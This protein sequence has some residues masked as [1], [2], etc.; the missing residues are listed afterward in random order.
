MKYTIVTLYPD[1]IRPYLDAAILGRAQKNNKIEVELIDLRD[2]GLGKYKQ[3][4][5]TPYGGG[6]GMILRPD[7]VVPAIK[8][9]EQGNKKAR[10]ILLSPEGGQFTQQHAEDIKNDDLILIAGRFEGFDARIKK[11]IDEVVSIG[12]YILCGG[13]IAALAIIEASARLI[14]GVLGNTESTKEE[15]FSNG[16]L[17]YPQYTKPDTYEGTTIPEVLKSGNHAEISKWRQ[18]N[19]RKI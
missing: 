4:D 6:P 15:T 13:E 7:V 18:E 11:Y 16:S 14:P 19:S 8:Q 1:A 12:P 2:F 9:A 17:E 5:D 3:V 10:K